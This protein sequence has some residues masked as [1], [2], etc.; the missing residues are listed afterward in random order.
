MSQRFQCDR[1]DD[2]RTGLAAAKA[3]L[4]RGA[5]VVFPTDSVY[6]VACDAFRPAATSALRAAKGR[7]PDAPLPVLIGSPGTADGIVRDLSE[8]AR[9][10]MAAFWP[11]PLTLI[12]RAQPSLMWEVDFSGSLGVRMPLHPLALE[13]LGQ[14][15]PLAATG[16]NYLGHA[17]PTTCADAQAQL[18]D[19]VAIYLDAG[20]LR[21]GAGSAVVDVTVTPPRLRRAGDVAEAELV[22]VC[23][24]LAGASGVSELA[25]GTTEETVTP[26]APLSPADGLPSRAHQ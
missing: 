26:A 11:G 8:A 16:A 14:S 20:P 22:A 19:A 10:L 15:G 4:R 24:D 7:A 1:P 18:G 13:L 21:G 12:A 3:A 5:L 23:P 2:R 25:H 17:V 6:A 9:E